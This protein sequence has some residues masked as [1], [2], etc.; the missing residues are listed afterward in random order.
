MSEPAP[1][2]Q[3][4]RSFIPAAGVDA[5][6]P[7]YDPLVRLLGREEQTRGRLVAEAAIR[8]GQ[9]V[10][11]IGC[12]TGSL[13]L[14]VKQQHPAASVT[15]LDPDAKAL[16]RASAKAARA[17]AEIAFEQGFADALPWPDACFDRVLSSLMLHHLTTDEKQRALAEARRVLAPGGSLHVLDFG[18]P[19]GWLDRALTALI[20][21]GERLDDNLAGRLPDL[22]H[23]AGLRDARETGRIR[24]AFGVLAR[25]TAQR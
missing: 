6:L 7:F 22:M 8:P 17:G 4:H 2:Q 15:G 1:G 12:G 14:R 21:H 19:G 9:R 23:R 5:L 24:T 20:H 18:P 11:E 16:A 10:L 25:Y 3:K 13:V